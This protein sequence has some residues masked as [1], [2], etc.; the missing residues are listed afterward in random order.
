[1]EGPMRIRKPDPK[2]K[3]AHGDA[4]Q[5]A[6]NE[7]RVVGA[8]PFT[9]DRVEARRIELLRQHNELARATPDSVFTV[10]NPVKVGVLCLGGMGGSGLV[11]RTCAQSLASAGHSVHLL[12]SL[13]TFWD[14]A[15]LE[16]VTVHGVRAPETPTEPN[17]SWTEPLA[18]EIVDVVER[19][20]LEVL[21]VHYAAGLLEAAIS[22]KRK[23]AEQGISLKVAATLHGSEV[24]IWGRNAKHVE[25]MKRALEQCDEVTAVSQHLAGLAVETFGL[26]ERP[27]VI[28][29]AIDETRFHPGQWSDIRARIAPHGEVV[30]CHVSNMRVVKRPLDAI[31]T[32]AK[33]CKSGVPAKMLL[34]GDGPMMPQ[35]YERAMQQGVAEQI[36]C[37][38]PLPPDKVAKHVAACDFCLV[39]SEAES[40]CLAALEAMAMGTVVV[41]TRNGGLEEIM[42]SVDPAVHYVDRVP[43]KRSQLL[44]SVGDTDHIAR[45]CLE[46][47][48]D[49]RRYERVQRQ[50]VRVPLAKYPTDRQAQAY[51]TMIDDLRPSG[52]SVHPVAR[53]PPDSTVESLEVPL[54]PLSERNDEAK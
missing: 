12:T 25:S 22:A 47:I 54:L 35:V 44:A 31:D 37:T 53:K 1:M 39:T 2:K 28:E 33:V 9:L 36:L 48:R 5:P 29:N 18:D 40:F 42:V 50:C 38:G 49:P 41:G 3:S 17:R 30:F 43:T 7:A 4:F 15:S 11:A 20:G 13:R 32:F 27:T 51:L 10:Q 21:S 52:L 46:L 19:E 16:K 26:T 23:L 34:I 6:R 45:I 24:S 8:N 14:D